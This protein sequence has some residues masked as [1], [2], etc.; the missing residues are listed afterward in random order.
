MVGAGVM[1]GHLLLELGKAVLDVD[2][3]LAGGAGDFCLR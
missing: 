2:V 3:V 1:W